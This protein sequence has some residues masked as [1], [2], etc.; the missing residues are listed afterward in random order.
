M[1]KIL[2]LK[3]THSWDILCIK[4]QKMTIFFIHLI[5]WVNPITSSSFELAFFNDKYLNLKCIYSNNFK[6]NRCLLYEIWMSQRTQKIVKNAFFLLVVLSEKFKYLEN[7]EGSFWTN[8][9]EIYQTCFPIKYVKTS[10]IDDYRSNR[11]CESRS[12]LTQTKSSTYYERFLLG[13]KTKS[14][15]FEKCS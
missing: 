15:N 8:W 12:W 10:Q 11:L 2:P 9:T 3:A 1:A 7:G 6:P 14:Q 4:Y 13:S 5:V